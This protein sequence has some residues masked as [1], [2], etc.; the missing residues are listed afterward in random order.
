MRLVLWIVFTVTL[1]AAELEQKGV[2]RTVKASVEVA[3]VSLREFHPWT[4]SFDPGASIDTVAFEATMPEHGHG[5]STQ[6]TIQALENGSFLVKGVRFHMAGNWVLRVRLHDRNGWDSVSIPFRVEYASAVL[7]S[8]WIGAR[9]GPRA[10]PSN[11]FAD[12]P[13][14]AALGK[15][16]FADKRLS[17]DGTVSCAT[18]HLAQAAFADNKRFSLPGLRRNTQGL[19]GIADASWFFWDGRRD[20]LWSQ[21]LAPIESPVEMKSNRKAAVDLLRN[22]YSESYRKLAGP[23]DG[24]VDRTFTNLGKFIAAYQRTLSPGASRFDKYVEGSTALT[25]DELAG[26]QIFLKPE[27]QCLNCHNGPLFTNHAF[28]NIGT[29]TLDGENPDFGRAMGVQALAFDAFNCRSV[30]S[31]AAGTCPSQDHALSG[32]HD[33]ALTGA[34]KTPSLRNVALTAP[35]LHD[36]SKATL[37][38]VIEHYRHPPA[39]GTELKP[40]QITDAEA[41]QL[42][43]FLKTLTS[44]PDAVKAPGRPNK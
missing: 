8:L 24:D 42:V 7:K 19:L 17:G 40:L 35:Y 38:D 5:L 2:R 28:H 6:P 13:A 31:D 27:S 43:A 21:A 15:Q 4:L 14:A 32:D 41:R 12:L 34:F 36:G 39:K 16:L 22:H 11:R 1:C 37:E 26:L 18:C 25:P 29:A 3:G 33:G 30:F 23:L 10:D 20:S 44:V 9:K